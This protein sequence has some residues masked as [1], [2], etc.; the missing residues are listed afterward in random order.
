MFFNQ[1]EVHLF[2]ARSLLSLF[3]LVSTTLGKVVQ[4]VAPLLVL[5]SIT[6]AQVG[7]KEEPPYINTKLPT[8]RTIETHQQETIGS[9]NLTA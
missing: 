6:T 2:L 8:W 5:H 9:S 3:P 7:H 4:G 1:S